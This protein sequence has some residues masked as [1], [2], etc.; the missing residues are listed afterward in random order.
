MEVDSD[1]EKSTSTTDDIGAA[2]AELARA[3]DRAKKAVRT[4]KAKHDT[5]LR[6]KQELE[7]RVAALKARVRDLE[8]ELEEPEGPGTTFPEG[9]E[10]FY[11]AEESFGEEAASYLGRIHLRPIRCAK[12]YPP[13]FGS[14]D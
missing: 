7:S 4:V 5:A 13:A 6:E 2:L 10:P 9:E 12:L 11:N 1:T 14:S 8:A 3:A